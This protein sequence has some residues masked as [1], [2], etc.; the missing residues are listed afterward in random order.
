MKQESRKSKGELVKE[1]IVD[2]SIELFNLH[3]FFQTSFQRIA[4]K[5]GMK[6]TAIIHHYKNKLVLLG[7]V[8]DRIFQHNQEIIARSYDISDNALDTLYKNFVF[9]LEWSKKYPSESNII[10]LLYYTATYDSEYRRLY[11]SL[12]ERV[13]QRY[14]GY[15]L[16]GVREGIFNLSLPAEIVAQLLHDNLVG[17]L[18]NVLSC[19]SKARLS[20]GFTGKVEGTDPGGNRS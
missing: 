11:T 4:D 19:K 10:I 12:L 14:H 13:R 7:A 16:A 5:C 18:I 1:R 9:N 15:I 3:G 2:A 17:S 6:Q 8:V 20:K